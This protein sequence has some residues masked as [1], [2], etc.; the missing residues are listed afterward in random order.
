[1]GILIIKDN[2]VS[3]GAKY[4]KIMK[5]MVHYKLNKLSVKTII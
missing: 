5:M 1:M 4:K 3:V 2:G